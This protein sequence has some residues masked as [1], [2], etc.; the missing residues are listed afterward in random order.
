[1][2]Q[3]KA[4][5]RIRAAL[6]LVQKEERV[7]TGLTVDV[8]VVDITEDGDEAHSYAAMGVETWTFTTEPAGGQVRF[9]KQ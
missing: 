5:R 2:D 1:M 4:V 6:A 8:P 9:K 7:I 3:K